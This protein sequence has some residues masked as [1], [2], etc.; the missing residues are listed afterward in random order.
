VDSRL[1]GRSDGLS[2]ASAVMRRHRPSPRR[3]QTVM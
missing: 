2:Y 1:V 3:L